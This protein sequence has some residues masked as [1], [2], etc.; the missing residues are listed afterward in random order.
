MDSGTVSPI[1]A[2][3]GEAGSPSAPAPAGGGPPAV[4]AW[5]WSGASTGARRWT[6]LDSD[7]QRLGGSSAWPLPFLVWGSVL[8]EGD[9]DGMMTP[10][11]LCLRARITHFP[12]GHSG[13]W[14]STEKRGKKGKPP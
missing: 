13:D 11:P 14:E 1:S 8:T 6:W 12:L 7:V 5:G 10:R 9:G 4:P 3:L 2:V